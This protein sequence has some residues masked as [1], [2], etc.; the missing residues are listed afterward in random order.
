[1]MHTLAFP[2]NAESEI[3]H[4]CNRF[5]CQVPSQIQALSNECLFPTP[6]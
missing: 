4:M 2:K 6:C 5:V 3:L 1:M